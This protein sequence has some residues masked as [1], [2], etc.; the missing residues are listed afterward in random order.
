[1]R[2]GAGGGGR[3]PPGVAEGRNCGHTDVAR[4]SCGR[5]SSP[6]TSVFSAQWKSGLL[7][8]REGRGGEVF[9]A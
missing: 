8:Q 2:G 1:M 4:S 7:A 3:E 6:V 5:G 9:G